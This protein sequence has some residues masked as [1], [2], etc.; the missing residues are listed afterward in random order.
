MPCSII[1][2]P[3]KLDYHYLIKEFKKDN[4]GKKATGS[5]RKASSNASSAADKKK[6]EEGKKRRG[7]GRG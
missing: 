7:F 2:L 3:T 1:G 4:A 5:R 6:R